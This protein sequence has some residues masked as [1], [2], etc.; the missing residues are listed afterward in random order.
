MLIMS[1]NVAGLSTTV[2]R[3]HEV[4]G[5]TPTTASKKS[6]SQVKTKT[7]TKTNNTNTVLAEYLHRHGNVD[8]LCVQEHKIPFRQLAERQEPYQCAHIAGYDSFWSCNTATVGTNYKKRGFNGVVTFA[9]HGL[10]Q[11]ANAT[12][13]LQQPEFDQQGRC[14]MTDHGRFVLFN[15][16]V[17]ASSGQP[18][19]KKMQFLD[20]LRSAMQEQR[21]R[22]HR[23]VIL[24]GD[25]NITHLTLDKFWSDRVLFINDILQ[26]V[27]TTNTNTN[28]NTNN[29]T[30]VNAKFKKKK[31]TTNEND[32]DKSNN[33]NKT[34]DDTTTTSDTSTH[35]ASASDTTAN[36][37]ATTTTNTTP[38]W[39]LQL[40]KAWPIIVKAL[41][42]QRVVPITTT[43]PQ[44]KQQFQKYRLQ[45][46]LT[47]TTGSS[48]RRSSSGIEE[49]DNDPDEDDT[50]DDVNDGNVMHDR[51]INMED[52]NR[53][54]NSNTITNNDEEVGGDLK[55]NKNNHNHNDN[56]NHNHN[57]TT[58]KRTKKRQ[59]RSV[60][61]G[62]H[63]SNP[64]RC[65]YYYDFRARYYT[66][67]P[68]ASSSSL[69]QDTTKDKNNTQNHPKQEPVLIMEENLVS[70][71]TLQELMSKIAGIQWD[72]CMLRTI[73]RDTMMAT[74]R[75]NPTT[76]TGFGESEKGSSWCTKMISKVSPPRQWL[77]S[78]LRDDDM[79]DAF[80]YYHPHAEGRYTCWC[81][82][83]NKRYTNEGARIDYTI[84]DKSL[85]P[86]IQI[87]QP[88]P[89]LQPQPGTTITT[90]AT[91]GS[92]LRCAPTQV[93]A[94][95]LSSSSTTGTKHQQSNGSRGILF[96]PN[97][98]EAAL[99][100]VT[101]SGRYQPVSFAGGG[102]VEA[103]KDVLDTQFGTPHTG[104]IYTPPVRGCMDN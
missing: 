31:N 96:D 59:L 57:A 32:D 66:P 100:V 71:S 63:E 85:L 51:D 45:V 9:K 11:R 70:L 95:S 33:D 7:K 98:E 26:H 22:Y 67:F 80:R 103:T 43:N 10:T 89:Q 56:H 102:I 34:N 50:D 48:N 2:H 76:G 81:Q 21:T 104:M 29:N 25:L 8:I 20:A 94:V 39:K 46:D 5:T 74:T 65:E 64:E 92:F 17:P 77:T 27:N 1:W 3:I 6:T 58:K 44:T 12:T 35:N 30:L 49:D 78:L 36:T 41:Q 42:T 73:I 14:V 99:A 40:A 23:Q 53:E 54:R 101:A 90:A 62:S 93:S 69:L 97:S 72:E 37:I 47:G 86:Y 24:V 16:Y 13:I 91:T 4:Y 82:F 28:T 52:N 83:T 79:V 84:I 38:D 18:L 15:V 88:P 75:R 68:I 60:F 87:Q 55:K 61:L 19:A